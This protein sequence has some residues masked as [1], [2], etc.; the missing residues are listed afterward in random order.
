MSRG[1]RAEEI[2]M[3]VDIGQWRRLRN[4]IKQKWSKLTDE[5]LTAVQGRRDYLIGRIQ[6]RY[7]IARARAAEQVFDFERGLC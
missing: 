1:S 3:Q 4:R 6:A 5:D 7:G 2:G